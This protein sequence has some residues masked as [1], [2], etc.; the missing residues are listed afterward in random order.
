MSSID[1]LAIHFIRLGQWSEAVE[2]YREELGLS[3]PQAESRVLGLADEHSLGHP[4][5]LMSWLIIALSGFSVL[6]FATILSWF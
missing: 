6:L 3:I 4:N 5:R 1:S 2:L